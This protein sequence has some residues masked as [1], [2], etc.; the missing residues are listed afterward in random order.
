MQAHFI[1]SRGARATG[2]SLIRTT[3]T[4]DVESQPCNMGTTGLL[5]LAG[6]LPLAGC[7]ALFGPYVSSSTPVR[8]HSLR[9]EISDV[10]SEDANVVAIA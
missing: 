8:P 3:K 1:D 7:L 5:S 6:L 2:F 9:R 10:V 4:R